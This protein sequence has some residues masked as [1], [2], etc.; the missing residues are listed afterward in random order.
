MSGAVADR[1]TERDLIDAYSAL[2]AVRMPGLAPGPRAEPRSIH[3]AFA[4]QV[5]GKPLAAETRN[6]FLEPTGKERGAP[7]KAVP[8]PE[9][10]R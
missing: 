2:F 3:A 1:L 8:M 6:L 10:A 7:L 4:E 5:L 9:L